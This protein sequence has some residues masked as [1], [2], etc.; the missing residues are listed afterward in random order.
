MKTLKYLPRQIKRACCGFVARGKEEMLEDKIIFGGEDYE[1]G[2]V[3]GF[4]FVVIVA[5]L[6]IAAFI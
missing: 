4:C 1:N 5:I 3:A 6:L 2:L